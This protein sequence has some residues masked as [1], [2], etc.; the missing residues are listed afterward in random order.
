MSSATE[1][2]KVTAIPQ[3]FPPNQLFVAVSDRGGEVAGEDGGPRTG[4]RGMWYVG[5]VQTWNADSPVP[6]A[7]RDPFTGLIWKGYVEPVLATRVDNGRLVCEQS[8]PYFA[9]NPAAPKRKEKPGVSKSTAP[10]ES[11]VS[12]AKHGPGKLAPL[13]RPERPTP[14]RTAARNAGLSV[15]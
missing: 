4:G 14:S 7:L 6:L 13:V 3:S 11:A 15:E 12:R 9:V 2:E 10:S 8:Q 5:Q 1:V